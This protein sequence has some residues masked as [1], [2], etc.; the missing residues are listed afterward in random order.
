[1]AKLR[2]ISLIKTADMK[3][4]INVKILVLHRV[5]HLHM[6]QYLPFCRSPALVHPS[7]FHA[8]TS[9]NDIVRIGAQFSKARNTNYI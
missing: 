6:I 3:L 5:S 4:S 7:S 8:V 2:K 1:M 9:R